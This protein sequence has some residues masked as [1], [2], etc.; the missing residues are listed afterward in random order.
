MPVESETRDLPVPSRPEGD[1]DAVRLVV[2][3]VRARPV[4][5]AVI[6]RGTTQAYP[7]LRDGVGRRGFEPQ[8]HPEVFTPNLHLRAGRRGRH[9]AVRRAPHLRTRHDRFGG[10]DIGRDLVAIVD[11]LACQV[12]LDEH[13]GHAGERLATPAA[14]ARAE[15]R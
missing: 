8:L 5:R 10:A 11:E 15:V 3:A 6:A 1:V 4:H 9:R 2:R 13:T 7:E 12:A 14:D